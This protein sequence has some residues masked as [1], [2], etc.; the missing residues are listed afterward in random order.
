MKLLKEMKTNNFLY[1]VDRDW[2]F[3]WMKLTFMECTPLSAYQNTILPPTTELFTR[4]Y[5]FTSATRGVLS[6]LVRA[7]V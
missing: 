5:F 6:D 4:L 3:P 7:T 2:R 1:I